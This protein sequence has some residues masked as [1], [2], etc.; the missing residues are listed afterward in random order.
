MQKLLRLSQIIDGINES[1]GKFTVLLVPLMIVIGVWNT[2]GRKIGNLIGQN[3]SSNSLIEGQ[4][5]LFALVFLLGAAYTFKHNGHV[6]V[7]AFY[8]HWPP[9]R[10]TWVNFLGSIL[11]VIP[12]CS[13]MIYYVWSPIVNSW[14]VWEVSPDAGGLP[15]YPI[16][17]VVCIFFVLLLLQGISE[18]IKNGIKLRRFS[19]GQ[20]GEADHGL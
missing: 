2:L 4:A 20:E 9:K 16:K 13:L 10:Q 5:Y 11:F 1:V 17:S 14:E 12:F 3:L 15:R 7:D 6:R 19:L 8:D 18:A